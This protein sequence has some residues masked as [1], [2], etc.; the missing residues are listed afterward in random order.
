[1]TAAQRVARMRAR[2]R[3]QG[4]ADVRLWVPAALADAMR[5]FGRLIRDSEDSPPSER[6]LALAESLARRNGTQAPDVIRR[7]GA[8]CDLFIAVQRARR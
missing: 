7:N 4:L 1:M 3:H 5:D 8:A 2:R 6:Q